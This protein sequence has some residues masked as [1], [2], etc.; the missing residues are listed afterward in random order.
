M[1]Y[2]RIMSRYLLA[3]YLMTPPSVM[4]N[5]SYHSYYRV[6]VSIRHFFDLF[7][8]IM[9]SIC[10]HIFSVENESFLMDRIEWMRNMSGLQQKWKTCNCNYE[11]SLSPHF[12][13]LDFQ[14]SW[15]NKMKEKN[16]QIH[17]H[18]QSKWERDTELWR[19]NSIWKQIS[20]LSIDSE[21]IQ[22]RSK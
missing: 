16:Q 15:T 4:K 2:C 6:F 22:W 14:M 20:A 17:T 1:V 12:I 5:Y 21:G 8:I 3:I 18:T 19:R 7:F 10:L 9:N 13:C 11:F